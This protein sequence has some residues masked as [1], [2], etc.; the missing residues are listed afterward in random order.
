[1]RKSLEDIKLNLKY[2]PCLTF[3]L[4]GFI[5]V[6]FLL[7]PEDSVMKYGLAIQVAFEEPWRFVTNHFVHAGATH[8]MM[9]F[10]G[11]VFLGGILENA[12]VKRIHILQGILM[13]MVFSDLFILISQTIRPSIV[14]GFSGII[15]GFIGLMVSIVGWRGVLAL[16]ILFFGF[17][18]LIMGPNIAWSGHIGGFIGGLILGGKHR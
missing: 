13:A 16:A 14:V 17:G 8:F 3:M 1:M 5:T 7:Q 11:L 9:N 18:I 4:A 12:G 15:Y 10:L 2:S 6:L